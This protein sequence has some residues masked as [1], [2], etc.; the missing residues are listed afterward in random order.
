MLIYPSEALL[1]NIN[2]IML[3]LISVLS[4]HLYSVKV[5]T[6]DPFEPQIRQ[7]N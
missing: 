1:M 3:P 2:S 5:Q 4:T 6:A 7:L